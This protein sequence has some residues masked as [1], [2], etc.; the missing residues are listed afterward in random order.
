MAKREDFVVL[1]DMLEAEAHQPAFAVIRA[2]RRHRNH[3]QAAGV[4]LI[5]GI[6]FLAIGTAV[7]VGSNRS[8]PA[9]PDPTSTNDAGDPDHQYYRSN[10]ESLAAAPS[11]PLYALGNSCRPVD[12][13]C[14]PSKGRHQVLVSGDLAASWTVMGEAPL[15]GRLLATGDGRLW[16]IGS[17]YHFEALGTNGADPTDVPVVVSAGGSADG[18]RTWSLWPLDDV[19]AGLSDEASS[20]TAGGT[21]WISHGPRVYTASGIERPTLTPASP[22]V[23]DIVRIIAIGPDHAV[24]QGMTDFRSPSLWFETTDRGAHWARIADP[25]AGKPQAGSF[26]SSMAVA[27]DDTWWATCVGDRGPSGLPGGTPHEIVVSTD[28]GRTWRDRGALTDPASGERLVLYPISATTAWHT[29]NDI[30][31]TVDGRSWIPVDRL[32]PGG[33]ASSF[34]AIDAE[35]A[36]Y[37]RESVNS[38]IPVFAVTRDGGGTWT[39]HPLPAPPT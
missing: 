25:C 38:T 28:G 22:D 33:I 23:N 2:R 16:I 7:A 12:V 27:R 18:G 29:D 5:I 14:D 20:D 13:M 6:L 31:R 8:L 3:G 15:G 19:S 32:R 30:K 35:T 39:T 9:T 37:I 11:G 34:V 17:A 4:S 26:E 1:R 24:V 36:V 10:L 21:I